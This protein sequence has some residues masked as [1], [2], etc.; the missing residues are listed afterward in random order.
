MTDYN[1]KIWLK[2]YKL[3]PFD[4]RPTMAPYPEKPLFTF[5]DDAVAK[6]GRRP[7]CLYQGRTMTYQELGAL[8]DRLASGLRSLGVEPGDRVATVL[9]TSPQSVISDFAIQKAGAVHVPCSPLHR[10]PELAHEIGESG[11]KT[12]ICLDE[13]LH[14]V[15]SEDLFNNLRNVITTSADDFSA[16][17]REIAEQPGR[18]QL[19]ELISGSDPTPPKA[20]INPREDLALLVFTGGATG[21]PKGVM[22]THHNL[23]ANSFQSLPWVMAPLQKGIIGKSSLLIGIPAF[24]SY[25]HWAIRASVLWGLKMIMVPDPRDTLTIAAL[26]KK[27]RPFMAPLVPTQYMKLLEHGLSR[28]NTTFTSGAAPLPPELAVRFKKMTG[29]PITEAYGL[30]ETSPVTHFNLSSFS[31]ITGFVQNEKKASIGVPVA[32]TEAK[33]VDPVVGSEVPMGEVGELYIKGPQIMKGYWPTPGSGLA[34]GWLPT[35]DLCR[36]DE[37]GYFYLVDRDKDMINVSGNKVYSTRVDEVIFEHPGV[38]QA[39]SIGIPD[40]DRPGS[41]RVKAF[42][43]LKESHAGKVTTEELV[44]HCKERLAPYAVPKLV[45]FRDSLPM[46]V[47]LKLFKKQ[48]RDE[49]IGRAQTNN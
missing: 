37:D 9:N 12:L 40:N 15:G 21:R 11:A 10:V 33:L 44:A 3:G 18:L 43:V 5:L 8:V 30:T 25:G 39:V 34:N 20:D 24:H 7:A 45:E 32:D 23:V 6:F 17:E 38:A 41:E 1:K 26:L 4:L 35:G 16:E 13:L 22:L 48:L 2:S 36:M 49:E 28:T 29:M 42:V 27:N 31:K 46:T 14:E 47:T 19:R